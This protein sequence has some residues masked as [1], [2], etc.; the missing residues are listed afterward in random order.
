MYLEVI[1][2]DMKKTEYRIVET[3]RKENEY[4]YKSWEDE[5]GNLYNIEYFIIIDATFIS[6]NLFR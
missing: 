2:V 5:T 3:W 6:E 1:L 4:K